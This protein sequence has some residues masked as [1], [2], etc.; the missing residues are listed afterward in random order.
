LRLRPMIAMVLLILMAAAGGARA[1]ARDSEIV[2]IKLTDAQV[3][4]YIATQADL[5]GVIIRLPDDRVDIPDTKSRSQVE[6]ILRRHGFGSLDAYN[7]VARNIALV[8]EGVDPKTR[9]YVGPNV[10]LERQLADIDAD[11]T[12]AQN[13]KE[14]AK[15]QIAAQMK[16]V[17]PLQFPSNVE[18]VTRNLDEIT[19]NSPFGGK[20]YED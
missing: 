12:V 2:Q 16:A 1:Q 15:A 14:E 13:E 7:A 19:A 18:L 6:T 9:T 11:P 3:K 10:M 8:L 17:A 4:D 20:A 5:A